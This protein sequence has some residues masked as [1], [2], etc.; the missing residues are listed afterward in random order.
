MASNPIVSSRNSAP[1]FDWLSFGPDWQNAHS[2]KMQ[3]LPGLKPLHYEQINNKLLKLV[4]SSIER[5]TE[6]DSQNVHCKMSSLQESFISYGIHSRLF[7]YITTEYLLPAPLAEAVKLEMRRTESSIV[8]KQ[9][10]VSFLWRQLTFL[11]LCLPKCKL[12]MA[13]FEPL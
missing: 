5:M 4:T 10:F 3:L 8:D 13:K 11:A 7:I 12:K 6:A 2:L 9:K 1:D